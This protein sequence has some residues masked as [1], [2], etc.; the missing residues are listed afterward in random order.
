MKTKLEKAAQFIQTKSKLKPRIGLVLGSGLGPLVDSMEN[1]EFISYDDIPYFHKTT[2]V[3]HQGRLALG[4]LAGVDVAV[5]QGR[6]H[7]YEGHSQ[8]D[9]VFPVRLLKQCGVETVILTN[10]SG[11]INRAY[12]PGELVIIG[13]HINLT[14]RNPLLGENL[15]FLGERFPDMSKVYC[16]NL[17]AI[18][19]KSAA[20]I[21]MEIKTGIYAGVLGPSYETPAEVRMLGILG[22]DMVGMSTVPESI[23]AHHAGLKVAGL[24]CITNMAA[25][26]LDQP[27]KHEDIKDQAM[28]VMKQFSQLI[29]SVIKNIK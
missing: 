4:K 18:I 2:V 11:G 20:S 22:A 12:K 27:L 25:G 24:S 10:A 7:A 29:E 21:G 13:D 9:V 6:I 17:Q 5:M 19:K 1:V 26:I 28:A 8:D 14:G 15:D 16:P 23:A 3:G